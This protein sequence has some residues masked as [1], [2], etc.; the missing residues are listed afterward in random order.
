M[1]AKT[2]KKYA[3]LSLLLL[4]GLLGRAQE[5]G[6]WISGVEAHFQQATFDAIE[7]IALKAEHTWYQWEHAAFRSGLQISGLFRRTD[8]DP[9]RGEVA[10]LD[11]VASALIITGIGWQWGASDRWNS[12]AEGYFGLRNYIITGTNTVA[13]PAFERRFSRVTPRFDA[14]IRSGI[15]YRIW[16]DLSLQTGV[17][18]SL[19]DVGNPLGLGAGVLYAS[20]DVLT[21]VEI[22]LRW[23]FR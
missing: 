12:Y 1:N 5:S 17:T 21:L 10:D 6:K 16:R 20:P 9:T 11:M 3:T 15:G 4:L 2:M 23:R 13:N 22:G 19:M 8:P 18:F 7:G 14:G